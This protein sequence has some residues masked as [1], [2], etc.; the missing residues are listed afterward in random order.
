MPNHT[1]ALPEDFD[2]IL[3]GTGLCEA[4]LAAA[5]SRISL[6][7][8]HLDRNSYYGEL[9]ATHSLN[10][11]LDYTAQHS[12]GLR[13]TEHGHSI[14]D[15][16]LSLSLPIAKDSSLTNLSYDFYDIS[17]DEKTCYMKI[18]EATSANLCEKPG[19]VALQKPFVNWEKQVTNSN[20]ED[21]QDDAD[22]NRYILAAAD[23][24]AKTVP[25]TERVTDSDVLTTE[26]VTD[27]DVPTTERVTDSDVPTTERV[28]DSDVP[29]TERVKDSDVPTTERVTDSD[30]PTTERVTD[31]DV[32]TTERVTDSDVPTTERVTDSDVPTTE[33]VT[34]SDVPTTE[35]VTD[36]DV[37]TT[38]RVTD[39]DV[40][41][42][43]RVTDF[44]VP[45]TERVTDSDALTT[46]R[47][48]DSDVPTTERVTDSDVPTTERVTDSD[49]PTTEE[50][51]EP[52]RLVTD[53]SIFHS[54]SEK[55]DTTRLNPIVQDYLSSVTARDKEVAHK[56]RILK[57]KSNRFILDLSPKLLF[58]RG[59][60]IDLLITSDV[61]RYLE[62]RSITQI[63]TINDDEFLQVVPCS[64][65][66][67]FSS[68]TL[69]MVEKR[70]LM[71]LLTMCTRYKTCQEYQDFSERPFVEFL[72]TL[73]LTNNLIKYVVNA[74]A[75]V[76][77]NVPTSVG[78]ERTRLFINSLGRY[79]PT[80]FLWPLYGGEINQAFCRM[81]AVF[82]GVYILERTV[83]QLLVNKKNRVSHVVCN[84][85]SKITCKWLICNP[86]YL[87][88]GVDE[89][90]AKFL[91]RA[92]IIACGSLSPTAEKEEAVLL[93]IPAI[94]S[95]GDPIT[96]IE[97]GPAAYVCPKDEL[98]LRVCHLTTSSKG[99]ARQ[100]LEPYVERLFSKTVEAGKPRLMLACYF[101]LPD[102]SEEKLLETRAYEN[103]LVTPG[104][105]ADISS[106]NSVSRAKQIF[107]LVC[108]G[109]EFLPRPPDPENIIFCET[110]S[111]LDSAEERS[112]D[113]GMQ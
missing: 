9:E 53:S 108:P 17:E 57:K 46:E 107:S 25:T 113:Q 23:N 11:I 16:E 82:G 28:T 80:P 111:K 45:T 15:E 13:V 74:I 97:L 50:I 60:M 72:K 62:F 52:E 91:S 85:G 34:D 10:G 27:S 104:P 26:R 93:S 69:S 77:R 106:D 96:V 56:L 79:G 98:N 67:I 112:T 6:S 36:S 37:P 49:V 44:D 18:L 29:T 24:M 21:G 103:L 51:I 100:D 41:T 55:S 14:A 47:V 48:T 76:P 105:G 87:P 5:F 81:S 75:M 31:S 73:K 7:V 39:S 78:M 66:D 109:E 30:V 83:S 70:I 92:I 35:R 90:D 33:R 101:N 19:N 22:T 1:D 64:R 89:S 20:K 32:P 63:L 94:D 110:D 38:E 86:G 84:E 12:D 59:E 8:L 40:P 71:K 2:V 58:A 99:V 54:L 43:E 4:I 95:S 65:A 88:K 61:A 68:K 3:L 102:Y 42:T